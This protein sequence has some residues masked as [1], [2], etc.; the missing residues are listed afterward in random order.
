FS[1]VPAPLILSIGN[2]GGS[3]SPGGFVL[4]NTHSLPIRFEDVPLKS[5][6]LGTLTLFTWRQLLPEGSAA[7]G[8]LNDSL[9]I[10]YGQDNNVVYSNTIIG[11]NLAPR[12]VEPQLELDNAWDA[13]FFYEDR[14]N[15]FYVMT[16][17]KI[18][19]WQ[20]HDDF[21]ILTSA[22]SLQGQVAKIPP[23]IFQEQPKA[24]PNGDP[25][26]A[27][28][29][30]GGNAATIRA[31]LSQTTAIRA[32]IGSVTPISYHGREISV[33]GS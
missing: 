25:I 29:A 13:P 17:E 22:P 33:S 1:N 21:A 28:N 3:F 16:S 31:Y 8:I 12:Y 6:D 19:F 27:A 30:I 20:N 5:N 24:A 15:V 7:G 23:L 18:S 14:R 10:N 2:P 11:F 9:E 32:G 4:H 26:L